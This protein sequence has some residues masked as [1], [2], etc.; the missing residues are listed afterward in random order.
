M[1]YA[2]GIDNSVESEGMDRHSIAWT[3]AQLDVIEQVASYGAPTVVLQMGGGQLDSSPI[4]NNPNVSALIWGGYP[5]QDGGLALIDTITGKNAP[6]GRLPT[7]QYPAN[8][9]SQIP[10]TDMTLRANDTTGSPGRTYQWYTGTPIFEFGSGL[11]YTN[12]SASVEDLQQDSYSISSLMDGCTKKY[13]DRC[14]FE[15]INVDVQNTGDVTSDYVTLGFLTGEHGPAPHPNKRLVNYTRLHDVEA[16]Q[17]QTAKLNL[18]LGSLARVD[19]MGNKVLYPG[20]YA[21]MV[22]VQ[23]LAM[24]NFT[25]TGEE[26][27][28]EEWPQAPPP[29]WQTSDYFVGGYGST[30][31]QRVLGENDDQ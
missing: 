6:A 19:E 25:L 12:F 22:D 27:M 8:Y 16:S 21:L 2:D 1:I 4:V 26:T 30:Y 23:P 7:T 13:K 20:D 17:T 14:S 11:H 28:L 15:T 29:R 3:G 5:G 31:H 18:T 10:M 24:V 9:V